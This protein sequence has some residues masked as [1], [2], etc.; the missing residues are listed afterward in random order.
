MALL[1]VGG[2]LLSGCG[3][4]PHLQRQESAVRATT[5]QS[6]IE[7]NQHRYPPPISPRHWLRVVSRPPKLTGLGNQ[8]ELVHECNRIGAAVRVAP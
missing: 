2:L 7:R 6:L 5:C 8:R 3:A 4:D 1:L